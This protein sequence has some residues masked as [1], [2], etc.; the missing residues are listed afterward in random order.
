MREPSVAIVGTGFSALGAAIALTKSEYRR[1]TV[2]EKA[3]DFG[4][5]W[6]DNMHP[7]AAREVTSHLHSILFKAD[8]RWTRSFGAQADTHAHRHQCAAQT[9]NRGLLKKS[10]LQ[11]DACSERE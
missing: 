3:D 6:R 1:I 8:T 7:G 2:L 4:D 5:V 11:H 10:G 9:S